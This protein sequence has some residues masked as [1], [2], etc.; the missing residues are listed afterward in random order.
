[1]SQRK[2][3]TS[4]INTNVSGKAIRHTLSIRMA[5]S[6]FFLETRKLVVRDSG[7]HIQLLS[8]QMA[9]KQ[10]LT[11]LVLTLTQAKFTEGYQINLS[12]FPKKL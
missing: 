4:T 5:N 9:L 3:T 12:L 7:L 2:N 6:I 11:A 1:M 10:N 8:N